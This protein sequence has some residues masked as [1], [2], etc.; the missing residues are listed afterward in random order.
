[1]PSAHDIV[2]FTDPPPP[3]GASPWVREP[4][5]GAIEVAPYDP[6]W[7]ATATDLIARIRGALGARALDVTHVGSTSVPGL[8]AKPIIDVDLVVAYPGDEPGWLPPLEG[9]GFVLTIREPW[10]HEHRLVKSRAHMANI[11]VFGPESPE[12]WKHRTFR[13]WLRANPSDRDEYA[14]VK[15]ETAAI[16]TSR[17]ESVMAYNDRKAHIIHAIYGR[18]FRAA[19]LLA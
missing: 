17:R 9:A 1:M 3:P 18:A 13:D 12:T 7:P 16:S 6:A 4:E 10:W 19:G 5:S 11:H 15:L 8:P 2:T 14:A